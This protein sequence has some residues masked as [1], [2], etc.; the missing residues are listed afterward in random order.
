MTMNVLGYA[1]PSAKAELTPY[2]FE[3]RDIRADDVVIEILYCGICHSDVHHV[4]ND[5]GGTTYPIVPGHEIIGRVVNVG[6]DVT[7]FKPGD[8]VG[9]GCMVDS[10]QHCAA[11]QQG[12]EQYCEEGPTLTFD[13]LDRHDQMRTFGG[14]SEK[15]IVREKFVLRIPEGLDLKGAGPLLCA[16]I[17]SWSPLRHW[18]VREGTNVGVVGLGGLGHMMLKLAKALG[19]NVTLF[20]RSPGKE[21]DAH[22]LGADN[23]VI[24]TDANQ[25]AAVNNKFDLIIDTV[26]YTHDINPYMPSLAINGTLVIVG[27]LGNLEP[28]LNTVPLIMGRKS[29]A[30]SVIGGIAETQELLDFCGEHEITADVEVIKVQDVNE[31]YKRMLKSDVKYRFVI[32]MAS[33]KS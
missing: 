27:F 5:W 26:P 18:R 1:A 12:L 28:T 21:Q 30:G 17:T 3:R 20:S 25:M 9:V 23:V 4:N 16:G 11:C 31:A 6:P 22:R 8:H 32:D 29:V 10:C 19:A 13:N 33:L 2:Q 7:R 15:I 14:Y 24:S